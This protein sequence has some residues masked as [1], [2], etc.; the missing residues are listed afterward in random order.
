MFRTIKGVI[1]VVVL[2][3]AAAVIA[4]VLDGKVTNLLIGA[5]MVA[6]NALVFGFMVDRRLGDA[7]DTGSRAQL[8]ALSRALAGHTKAHKTD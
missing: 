8:R 5:A 1:V 4:A 6:S 7:Y 2:I 3:D